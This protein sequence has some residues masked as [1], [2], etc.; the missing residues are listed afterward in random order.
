MTI[1]PITTIVPNPE[2]CDISVITLFGIRRTR[3]V[4]TKHI[5]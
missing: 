4:S 1:I 2:F 5:Y 3:I